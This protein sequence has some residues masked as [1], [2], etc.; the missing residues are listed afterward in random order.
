MMIGSLDNYLMGPDAVRHII[1]PEA[2]PFDF[3]FNLQG[4]KLIGDSPHLPTRGVRMGAGITDSLYFRRGKPLIAIAKRA[5]SG[6]VA[7]LF[8]LKIFRLRGMVG[9]YYYPPSHNGVT[10]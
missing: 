1:Q 8:P 7:M 2:V 10:S 5:V 4:G 3:A 6:P 9:I